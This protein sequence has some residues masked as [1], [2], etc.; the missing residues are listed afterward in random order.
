MTINPLE[1]IL[2]GDASV[3]NNFVQNEVFLVESFVFDFARADFLDMRSVLLD[4]LAQ[5]GG[6]VASDNV[7]GGNIANHA[8]N[9]AVL[10]DKSE[11]V[12]EDI[13]KLFAGIGLIFV[14]EVELIK[15]SGGDEAARVEFEF[16][17]AEMRGGEKLSEVLLI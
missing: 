2:L 15:R 6:F 13:E 14:L 12:G 9:S 11:M 4:K 10:G 8:S 17:G 5:V 7:M 3:I 1:E 16:I